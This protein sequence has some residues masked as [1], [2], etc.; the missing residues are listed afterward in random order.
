MRTIHTSPATLPATALSESSAR[1]KA[2]PAANR[3]A[4]AART[5]WGTYAK[6]PV[7]PVPMKRRASAAPAKSARHIPTS[8]TAAAQFT[9]IGGI[10]HQPDVGVFQRRVRLASRNSIKRIGDHANAHAASIA[11]QRRLKIA[12]PQQ[13]KFL[14]IRF[15]LPNPAPNAIQHL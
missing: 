5:A 11:R 9:D 13:G 8:Q 14:R 12:A 4:P 3:M 2:A 7:I 1:A 15:D 6:N 10:L